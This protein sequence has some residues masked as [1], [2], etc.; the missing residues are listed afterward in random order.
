MRARYL[1]FYGGRVTCRI[2]GESIYQRRKRELNAISI[3]SMFER[4]LFLLLR[5]KCMAF[6]ICEIIVKK[7]DNPSVFQV[8]RG[9]QKG[10]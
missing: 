8:M 10:F 2:L 9:R 7:C 4:P 5:G 6:E 3:L 1:V